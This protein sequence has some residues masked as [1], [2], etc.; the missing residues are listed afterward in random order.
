MELTEALRISD[1]VENGSQALFARTERRPLPRWR[2]SKL[3]QFESLPVA[4]DTVALRW[5]PRVAVLLCTCNGEPYL[6]EQLASIAAQSHEN[7][8]VWASDDGSSDATRELLEDFKASIGTERMAVQSGPARGFA[9]NFLSLA[10]DSRIQAEYYAYADQDDV[11]EKNK[12]QR[13]L[14]WLESVPA[15][16]PALYCSRTRLID[17]H[18][19]HLGFS[20]LFSRPPSF[21]NALMQNIGGGNTMMFNEAARKLLREAGAD[22]QVVSHD[23][24]AYIVVSGCGG[25]IFYDWQPS[26]RY[27]QHGAN[28]VGTN[29]GLVAKLVRLRLLW[30]GR[31]RHWHDLNIRALEHLTSRLTPENRKILDTFRRARESGLVGRLL[32]L[33]SSGVYRQTIAGNFGLI[34]AAAF[35]KL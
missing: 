30:Q 3:T 14:G 26:V 10:C 17:Q 35:K 5:A 22:I 6:G 20:P 12:L 24:W 27:R 15:D 25:K 16:V 23:W 11:W 18:D 8:Q 34:L 4:P 9:A 13:A 19:E 31:F 7:W 29:T 33:K 2:D 32:G 28:L 21:A 1:S